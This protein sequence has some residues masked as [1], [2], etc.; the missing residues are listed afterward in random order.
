MLYKTTALAKDA[1]KNR[2]GAG[3]NGAPSP[4]AQLHGVLVLNKPSGPTSACCLTAVKRLG[5]KKIGHAGTLDPL[6]SG[7]LLVLLGQATKLSSHLLV[8][9]HK[10]YSGRLRLGQITDTWDAQGTVIAESPWERTRPEDVRREIT[11]W[12]QLREQLVPPYSAAKCDGRPLYRLARE[13]RN[14]P[15]RIKH[16]Q[17]SQADTLDVSLPFVHFRVSCGSGTYIRSLAHSL[18]MRIG[19]GAVLTELVREYSFPFG[20]D[21]ACDLDDITAN[22][23][24][25]PEV[26]RPIAEALPH[27]PRVELTP[28]QALRVRNGMSVPDDPFTISRQRQKGAEHAGG[29]ALLLFQGE[30]IA[31]A[32]REDGPEQSGLRVLRGLWN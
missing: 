12:G 4:L 22:I 19:C 13:G 28:D 20:L 24:L 18:G 32:R 1:T 10:V 14:V 2:A 11:R 7:V 26:V 29:C 15:E 31:L 25:L 27:W 3:L 30:V 17:I 16:I 6:A 5:Q 8:G 21:A 9:G 23:A